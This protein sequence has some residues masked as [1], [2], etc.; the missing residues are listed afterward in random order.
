MILKDYFP[1]GSAFAVSFTGGYPL[2]SLE[3]PQ[4]T[5][6]INFLNG[7]KTKNQS[8]WR[9]Q[10]NSVFFQWELMIPSFLCGVVNV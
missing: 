1:F 9:V 10:E 8:F 6:A 7:V 3:Q 4:Q 2:I 5:G